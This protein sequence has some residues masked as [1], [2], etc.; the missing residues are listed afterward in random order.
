VEN[1]YWPVGDADV[2]CI[3]FKKTALL[4]NYE[5]RKARCVLKWLYATQ[6]LIESSKFWK[7]L[8]KIKREGENSS[9]SYKIKRERQKP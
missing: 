6:A 4:C 1:S 5:I 2:E 8:Q 7:M 9:V 3:L